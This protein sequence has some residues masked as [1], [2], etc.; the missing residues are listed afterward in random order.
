MHEGHRAARC[1]DWKIVA[2]RGQDWELYDLS[3]DRAEQRNLASSQPETLQKLVNFWQ[4]QCE[5]FTRM[6]TKP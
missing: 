6:V 3:Q 2:L 1:G 4:T 5:D